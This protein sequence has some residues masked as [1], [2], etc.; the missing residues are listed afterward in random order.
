MRSPFEK[1]KGIC[2]TDNTRVY[3]YTYPDHMLVVDR[4][5][6]VPV[7]VFSSLRHREY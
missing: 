7:I 4:P 6:A 2:P 3:I 1:L 5:Q